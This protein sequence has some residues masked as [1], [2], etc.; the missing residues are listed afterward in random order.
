MT[1]LLIVIGRHILI[2]SKI[3]CNPCY[4]C[5]CDLID[6]AYPLLAFTILI[7][8]IVGLDVY[9]YLKKKK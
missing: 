1:S 5:G 9:F 2:T 8:T 4:S 3:I 6:I 7:F